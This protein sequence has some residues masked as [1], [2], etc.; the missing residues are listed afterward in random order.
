MLEPDQMKSLKVENQSKLSQRLVWLLQQSSKREI[1]VTWKANWDRVL[2]KAC[3][4]SEEVTFYLTVCF[5]EQALDN[6]LS[7]PSIQ[8]KVKEERSDVSEREI[9]DFIDVELTQNHFLGW[10]WF[11]SSK[12]PEA[13]KS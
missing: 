7:Q 13:L 5:K 1:Q 4:Q 9:S 2:E 6:F 10:S 12:D 8:M 3:C 11:I